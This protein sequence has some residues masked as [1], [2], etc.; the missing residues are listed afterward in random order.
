MLREVMQ[1]QQW[2][3]ISKEEAEH[4]KK[5]MKSAGVFGRVTLKKTLPL[6]KDCLNALEKEAYSLFFTPRCFGE[7]VD[8][9][10]KR[11]RIDYNYMQGWHRLDEEKAK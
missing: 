1:K 5:A 4:C 6:H 2:K 10:W 9:R 11:G 3:F 7:L 8:F